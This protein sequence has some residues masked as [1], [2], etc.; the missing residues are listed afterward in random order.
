MFYRDNKTIEIRNLNN[1]LFVKE[2]I[3]ASDGLLLGNDAVLANRLFVTG[4]VSFN[5][6]VYVLE[7]ATIS[8]RLFAVGDSSFGG[9]FA[10]PMNDAA[11][12]LEPPPPPPPDGF[13]GLL[14]CDG[15][16]VLTTLVGGGLGAPAP[17][18]PTILS[19]EESP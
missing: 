13:G 4:D 5:R 12:L 8:K 9:D 2:A 3:T 7:D 10:L 17:D 19:G 16:M 11:P 14:D 6:R 15:G 18:A 1:R